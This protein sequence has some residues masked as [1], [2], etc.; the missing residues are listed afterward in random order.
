MDSNLIGKDRIFISTFQRTDEL[1]DKNVTEFDDREYEDKTYTIYAIYSMSGHEVHRVS[2]K[3]L[4]T[5][6][7][8]RFIAGLSIPSGI[9]KNVPDLMIRSDK[10]ILNCDEMTVR[11][12][13]DNI[14]IDEVKN[15]ELYYSILSQFKGAEETQIN[16]YSSSFNKE[17]H[18]TYIELGALEKVKCKFKKYIENPIYVGRLN[19]VS[20]RENN[21][22]F[23]SIILQNAYSMNKSAIQAIIIDDSLN[24]VGFKLK[25]DTTFNITMPKEKY[26]QERTALGIKAPYRVKTDSNDGEDGVIEL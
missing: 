22:E 12:V 14:C 2:A 25:N 13:A 19:K 20:I 7:M 23:K 21:I 6:S 15:T 4:R 1:I 3:Q 18:D 17:L 5:R 26:L 24:A 16:I 9:V 10:I 11:F 8:I